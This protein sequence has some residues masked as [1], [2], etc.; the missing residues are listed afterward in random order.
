MSDSYK[1]HLASQRKARLEKTSLEVLKGLLSYSG[2]QKLQHVE[3][4]KKSMEIAKEF[5]KQMDEE[6]KSNESNS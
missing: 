3:N 4:V 1:A 5:I 6:F 2:G